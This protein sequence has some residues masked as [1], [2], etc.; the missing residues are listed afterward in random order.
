M[1]INEDGPERAG[2]VEKMA[3]G[4]AFLRQAELD[5]GTPELRFHVILVDELWEVDTEAGSGEVQTFTSKRRAVDA[6]RQRAHA[7]RGLLITHRE[8]GA[9]QAIYSYLPD[10]D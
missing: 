8:S 10:S 2:R 7:A 4:L 9:I 5:V 6:A 1:H 3:R